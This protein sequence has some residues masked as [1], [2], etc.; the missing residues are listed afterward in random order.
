MPTAKPTNIDA[1][2]ILSIMDE[3]KEKL[4]YLAVVTPQVLEGLQGEEGQA[5][6]EALGPDLMRAFQEQINLEELYVVNH[7]SAEGFSAPHTEE[8]EE[9]REELRLLQKNTLELCRKMRALPNVMQQL[10]DFQETRSQAVIQ[11]L[12]TLDSMQDLTLKR[13][14]TTKEEDA[15]RNELLEHYRQRQEDATRRRNQLETDLANL[16]RECEKAQSQRTEILTKL[17][18]DLLDVK[19]SKKEKMQHLRERYEQ[20]RQKFDDDF[21]KLEKEYLDKITAMREANKKQRDDNAT[22]EGAQKK[23]VK[24]KVRDVHDLIKNYDTEVKVKVSD[25][26]EN[27]KQFKRDISMPKHCARGP[28]RQGVK[29]ACS[30]DQ[31][32]LQELSAHFKKVEAEKDCIKSEEEL[33]AARKAKVDREQ[34]KR[35]E[36]SALVQA[37][38]R[39]IV[40]REEFMAEKKKSKKKGKGGKKKK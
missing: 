31:K 30:Q 9:G 8:G 20:R 28:A 35:N 7:T 1:Q 26:D 13:L 33:S 38:W 17:K 11:F 19:E 14:T 21:A 29:F 37:F 27:S 40:R 24:T 6:Q 23:G 16:R 5:A 10:R 3:L 4:T 12:K 32:Q 22:E 18:A 25:L 39:G 2:R 34:K 15:S 36:A